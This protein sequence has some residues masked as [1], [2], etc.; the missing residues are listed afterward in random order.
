MLNREV[1]L[2][3]RGTQIIGK[4]EEESEAT[5]DYRKQLNSKGSPSESIAAGYKW[6]P[7]TEIAEETPDVEKLRKKVA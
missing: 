3:A 6:K 2:R 7:G 5:R 4:D 1:D